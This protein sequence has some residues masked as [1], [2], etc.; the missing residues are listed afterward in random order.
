MGEGF[1]SALQETNVSR[2]SPSL[3]FTWSGHSVILGL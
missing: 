2:D 1:P 3:S